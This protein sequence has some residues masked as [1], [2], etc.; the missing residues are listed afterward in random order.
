MPSNQRIIKREKSMAEF[1]VVILI[2]AG[3]MKTFISTFNEQEPYI[4]STGF[5]AI[6]QNFNNTVFVVHAQWFMDK[7]PNVVLLETL[8]KV[9][10]TPITVNNKGWL[11]VP[12]KITK[13]PSFAHAT[14]FTDFANMTAC[15]QIWQLAMNM[16][17]QLM[18]FS[19]AAIELR[20]QTLAN[21]S[22]G[23]FH[24]CRYLLP[25]G[26]YFEYDSETGKVS[27]VKQAVM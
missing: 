2:V 9:E 13:L 24:H 10:I 12:N 16:P 3:L 11:D 20:E 6:A 7:E 5:T 15:E 19:I 22:S 23:N 25:S 27:Q 18:T 21:N 4:T 1:V 14:D 17:M 26:Q 8:D